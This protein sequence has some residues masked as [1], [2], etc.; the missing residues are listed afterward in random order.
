MPTRSKSYMLIP[1]SF[2]HKYIADSA[3]T[4]LFYWLNFDLSIA[5]SVMYKQMFCALL[6]I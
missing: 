1:T 2:M 6:V 5:N 3:R 4:C